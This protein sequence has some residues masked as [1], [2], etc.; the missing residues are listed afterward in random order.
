MAESVNAVALNEM[1]STAS[2]P[3]DGEGVDQ[4]VSQTAPQS[5]DVYMYDGDNPD[6]WWKGMNVSMLDEESGQTKIVGKVN[7]VQPTHIL[8]D[9]IDQNKNEA[10]VTQHEDGDDAPPADKQQ[11]NIPEPKSYARSKLVPTT[12]TK[13]MPTFAYIRAKGCKAYCQNRVE[14]SPAQLGVEVLAGLTVAF[15]LVPEA[16]SFALLAKLPATVGLFAAFWVGAIA[17]IFGGRPGMISGATGAMAAVMPGYVT[18]YCVHPNPANGIC[19]LEDRGVQFIFLAVMFCGVAQA[20]CGVLHVPALLRLLPHTAMVGFVDGLAIV[21]GWAQF[22]FFMV[23][24]KWVKGLTA[25]YMSLEVIFSMAIIALWGP[26]VNDKVPGPL[27][28]LI[29]MTAVHWIAGFDSPTIRS[30]AREGG[31]DGLSAEFE[32]PHLPYICELNCTSNC[33]IPAAVCTGFGGYDWELV[34][35]ALELG[36]ILCAIGLIESL[37]TLT[38]V[39]QITGTEGSPIRECLGQ[40]LAN[41]MSG[42]FQSMGGCAMIGQTMINIGAGSKMRVSGTVAAFVLLLIV[43]VGEPIIELIPLGSLVGVMFMVVVHTFDWKTFEYLFVLPFGD[44]ITIILVTALA[45]TTN[46]AFAVGLGVVCQALVFSW[47]ARSSTKLLSKKCYVDANTKE[48][49]VCYT[50]VGPLFFGSAQGFLSHFEDLSLQPKNVVIRLQNVHVFDSTGYEALE[51]LAQTAKQLNKDARIYFSQN[52]K[53]P[54]HRHGE[55]MEHVEYHGDGVYHYPPHC[56]SAFSQCVGCLDKP[57]ACWCGAYRNTLSAIHH[58]LCGCMDRRRRCCHATI[59]RCCK[60]P[61]GIAWANKHFGPKKDDNK[62]FRL[63]GFDEDELLNREPM[64]R[65]SHKIAVSG[66]PISDIIAEL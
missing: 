9:G 35:N 17:S 46:L 19:P 1:N 53:S 61:C 4:K 42:L 6:T 15:A 56:C 20:L 36:L 63:N 28:A 31:G 18:R 60:C 29:V 49:T 22:E 51:H 14:F 40:G 13:P 48:A 41:V 64:L 38:L 12:L 45:V 52:M 21:I 24:H 50:I 66:G 26:C 39:D 37:M 57:R 65:H 10:R 33:T 25:L 2:A 58:G 27:V 16:V 34:G 44:S 7:G 59:S 47:A 54:L 23:D 11:E 55:F 30:F 43:L 32:M 8:V 62:S 3:S 5:L